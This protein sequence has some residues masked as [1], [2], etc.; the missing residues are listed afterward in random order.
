MSALSVRLMVMP[1]LDVMP[2]DVT[3]KYRLVGS[4]SAFQA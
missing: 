4:L 2:V 3:R 1:P